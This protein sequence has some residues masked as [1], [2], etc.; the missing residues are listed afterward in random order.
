LSESSNKK[1]L[2]QK[3]IYLSRSVAQGQGLGAVGNCEVVE[4]FR[5]TVS[6]ESADMDNEN[7]HIED[8]TPSLPENPNYFIN[9]IFF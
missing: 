4:I 9:S 6:L 7:V 8:A 3:A 2:S 5:S 1:Y